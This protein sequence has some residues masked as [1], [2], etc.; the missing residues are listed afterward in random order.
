MK[1]AKYQAELLAFLFLML[2]DRYFFDLLRWTSDLINGARL[3]EWGAELPET[4]NSTRHCLWL[5]AF[6]LCSWLFL[7]APEAQH[8]PWMHKIPL[9]DTVSACAL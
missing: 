4:D 5:V 2:M 1:T 6:P 8:P 9:L 7:F 3:P